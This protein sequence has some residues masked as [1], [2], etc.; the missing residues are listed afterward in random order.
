[1]SGSVSAGCVE[2][3]VVLRA[4]RVLDDDRPAIAGYGITD[5]ESLGVG[6]S[7]GGSIDVLIEPFR[8]CEVWRAVRL[9][10]ERGR[11]I[12]MATG[13]EPD[14]LRGLRLAVTDDETTGSIAP[15][16]DPRIVPLARRI[17][18]GN[19]TRLIRLGERDSEGLIFIE[20]FGAPRTVYIVGATE[21]GAALC[22]GARRLGYR[23]VVVD[24]RE[25][26]A[27]HERF[28]G[29]DELVRAWPEE[30]LER[31]AL[32]DGSYVVSL[33]HDPKFDLPTLARALRSGARYIG[34]LGSRR[35]HR[36]RAEKLVREGFSE[37]DVARIH[38]P[39][40]LDLGGE[41]P[42]EVA[43]AILAEM[44]A[45]RYG[46]SGGSLRDRDGVIHPERR[47]QDGRRC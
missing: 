33:S 24:P 2:N 46:K 11:P 41:D 15:E 13:I 47:V 12:A 44:Q 22:R 9:A 20:A 21:T 32:D 7:C 43:L 31:A 29:A 28:P 19:G 34:A 37:D 30:T 40:G 6:L 3:D 27:T 45:V 18:A 25:T 14:S 10:L 17:L 35:T 1:M 4:Q 36:K 26:Y 42:E 16:L 39:I 23:V 5:D 38:A 8:E